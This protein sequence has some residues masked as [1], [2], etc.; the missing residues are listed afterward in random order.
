MTRLGG[1]FAKHDSWPTKRR[2]RRKAFEEAQL[3]PQAADSA[4]D[5]AAKAMALAEQNIA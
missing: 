2:A 3:A 4:C 5:D 1:G